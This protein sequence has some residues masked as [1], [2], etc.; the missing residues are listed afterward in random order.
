ML[1]YEQDYRDLCQKIVEEGV[2]VD[3]E[4]TSTRC[5]TI[6]NVDLIY[7]VGSGEVPLLTTK[8]CFT[9][10]AI[11]E[12][13]GYYRRYDNATQF[14]NIGVK[15]WY[16]NSN[17]TESWLN[18]PNRKGEN[19]LGIVYGAAVED[20]ILRDIYEKLSEGKDDRGLIFDM[21]RPETFDKGCL[22]PCAYQH[23]W[24]LIG[25]TLDL[26]II[27]RSGDVALGRNA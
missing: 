14:D 20:G 23:V 18:N 27:Q 24:T 13:L 12:L 19:D 15:S 9:V 22:R 16:C 10:S 17:E 6:S 21:W 2:W 26:R 25:D 1:K 7:D 5:K 4:R 11:A 8:Q 3:N